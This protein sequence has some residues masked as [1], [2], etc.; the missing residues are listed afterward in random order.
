MNKFWGNTLDKDFS[1]PFLLCSFFLQRGQLFD[2]ILLI[3][4]KLKLQHALTSSGPD[5]PI[6]FFPLDFQTSYAVFQ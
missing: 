2:N 5:L 3:E 4:D 1:L 6:Y